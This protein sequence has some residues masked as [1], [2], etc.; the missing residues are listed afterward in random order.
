MMLG[1]WT[2]R[3]GS[4]TSS[5]GEF[6][7]LVLGS[8]TLSSILSSRGWVSRGNLETEISPSFTHFSDFDQLQ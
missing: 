4:W 8:W 5:K 3:R 1:S 2:L 7:D 6:L